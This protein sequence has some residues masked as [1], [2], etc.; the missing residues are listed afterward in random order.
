[1]SFVAGIG[2]TVALLVGDLSYGETS[3]AH[4][5]VKVGV[6]TGSLVAAVLGGAILGIR[7]RHRGPCPAGERAGSRRPAVVLDRRTP[8]HR[9]R[10]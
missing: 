5:D 1:M 6:L 3:T 7:S 4:T 9:A 2:F 8:G 10:T